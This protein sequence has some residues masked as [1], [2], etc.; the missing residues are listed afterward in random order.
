M[1]GE[2]VPEVLLSGHHA[3]I[4]RWRL[5]QALGRTWQRRPAM[6]AARGMTD[7]ERK[8]LDEFQ[9]EYSNGA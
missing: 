3:A 7:E 1:G 9:R 2:R 8:L 4:G 5:K 6:L